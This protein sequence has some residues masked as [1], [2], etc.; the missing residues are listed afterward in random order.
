MG[1]Q[2]ANRRV[3]QENVLALKDI[4]QNVEETMMEDS[5]YGGRGDKIGSWVSPKVLKATFYL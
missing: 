5:N 1:E 4:F 3:G 2:T